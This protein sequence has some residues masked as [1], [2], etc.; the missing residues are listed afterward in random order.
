MLTAGVR[1]VSTAIFSLA[2]RLRNL[3]MRLM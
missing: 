1:F 2:M 3:T